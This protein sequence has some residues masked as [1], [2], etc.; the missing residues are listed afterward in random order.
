MSRFFPV[1]LLSLMAIL[2]SLP[3]SAAGIVEGDRIVAVVGDEVIT[4]N[5]LQDH[6][7]TAISQLQ[8][9][10]TPLPASSILE[11]QMLERLVMDKVQLQY[12][13]ESGLRV[14]DVQLDQAIN[15]IAVS[16]KLTLAQFRDALKKDNVDFAAFREEI[17]TQMIIARLREREVESRLQ[18][19]DGE[20]DNYLENQAASGD[21]GIEYQAA[22]I[23]LRAPES[24]TPEQL[25]KLRAKAE[26]VLQK[27][28]Q[29][30]NFAELV[31][32]YSDAPDALQGGNLGWRGND[33]LPTLYAD[34]LGKLEPGGVSD[35]LRSSNGFHIIKLLDKRGGNIAAPPIT[36]THARHI[37][38][39]VDELVSETEAQRKLNDLRDRL[40]HGAE[41]AELA[42]LYSQDGSAAKGGDLGW[43]SPGD[44]V[45]DFER[46]MDALK[47]GE[48]SQV[49]HS[50]FGYHLIQVIE[51]RQQDVS[52][53]RR[54]L[55]ARQA[56]H[57]RRTDEAYQDWLRQLRDRAYVENRLQER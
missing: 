26:M 31:A 53:E 37:L 6:V 20:I 34:A 35:V 36:Q 49:V 32:A 44:T 1:F 45:P 21:Q 39:R 25:Q 28:R 12:A 3:A 23:L 40:L 33:R 43:L 38:I 17:R 2:Q 57:D 8:K 51:R 11:Q 27:A 29:G 5:E 19:S 50:P 54:R 22:H 55:N 18:I 9:Q 46:A 7:K 41:F 10:G 48:I 16:N 30:G 56:L 47:D 4:N 42:R 24:A 14:D 52:N 15:R 13:K